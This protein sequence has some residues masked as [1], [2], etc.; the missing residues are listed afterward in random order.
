LLDA[1]FT[2]SF[3]KHML[4]QAVSYHDLELIEPDFYRSLKQTL[5]LS[6]DDLGLELTFSIE[7]NDFG[8]INTVDLIDN[9]RHIPVTDE[10]KREYVQL[11]AHHRMV[12][13]INKQVSQ[14]HVFGR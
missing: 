6:L 9:G 13:S 14:Y 5:E 2:R 4:G 3:Y 11:V 8:R 1:H 12:A 10:N 7:S